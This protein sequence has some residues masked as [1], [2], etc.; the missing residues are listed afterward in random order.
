MKKF[1]GFIIIVLIGLGIFSWVKWGSP[2]F[3]EKKQ[4]QTS[5]VNVSNM[6]TFTWGGDGYAGYYVLK[7]TEMRKRLALKGIILKFVDDGGAYAD[8][9]GKFSKGEYDFI[10]L[11]ISSF[12]K[13]GKKYSYRLGTIPAAISDSKG[14]DGLAVFPEF[15]FSKVNDLDNP[16]LKIIYTGAS[17]TEDLIN[18]T[19]SNFDLTNLQE[20]SSWKIEVSSS[21]EVF[22]LALKASK[23]AADRAHTVYGMWDPEL[24]KA[25][26]DLGMTKIWSSENFSNYIVDVFVFS[27][28]LMSVHFDKVTEILR[29]YFDVLDYYNA[30][31][32]EQVK[33]LKKLTG[34]KQTAV[35]K[36]M[37][38]IH[39]Y[40]LYQN[41]HDEFGISTNAGDQANE[42]LVR[43]IY[44]WNDI[45]RVM[46]LEGEVENPYTIMNKKILENLLASSLK[47]VIA[48]TA[49]T[50]T[51]FSLLDEKG[52]ARLN[53][54]GIMKVENITFQASVNKVDEMGG[55]VIDKV[56]EKLLHNYPN[57]RILIAGHTGLGDELANLKLSQERANA[58]RQ[59]L[60]AV[61]NIN[62]NRILAKGFGS[63]RPPQ[64]KVNESDRAYIS[65]M[66]RVEF[67]LMQ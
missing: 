55:E 34:L 45:N 57:Y 14:A 35:E 24:S 37:N 36:L 17:P 51:D 8:R 66:S 53:E 67:I 63:S 6:E 56:S 25:V 47:P 59:T 44:A 1:I 48:S 10:V 65:R 39:W 15:K 46:K 27:N 12:I 7:S 2:Y 50:T 60:I 5:G 22:K 20:S 38:D 19:I 21:E 13:H 64:R 11:P 62:P 26:S 30:R 31:Q 41:A 4:M 33:E 42:G 32:D 18:L 49:S 54:T 43:T 29:T 61:Y 9:L 28:K 16:N 40:T 58:V 52:W 3:A 23:T